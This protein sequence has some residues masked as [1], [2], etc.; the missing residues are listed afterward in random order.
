[1]SGN[2]VRVVPSSAMTGPVLEERAPEPCTVVIL[3]ATGDLARRKLVPALYRLL[4]DG[5]LPEGFAIVGVSRSGR[6]TQVFRASLAEAARGFL[7]ADYDERAWNDLAARVGYVAGGFDEPATYLRLRDTLHEQQRSRGDEGHHLFYLATPPEATPTILANLN[8]A[9]LLRKADPDEP[10]PWPRVVLEKPFGHDLESARGLNEQIAELLRERQVFRIDHY[11]GKETVQNIL[12]FRFGNA[13]FEPIWNRKYIDHVQITA[14]E[15]L[16]L[17][18][19]G[20]FYDQAGVVRDVVQNHLLQVLAL[21][22]MEPPVSFEADDLRDER[23]QVLRSLRPLDPYTLADDVVLAQVDGYHAEPQVAPGS[24]TPTFAALR[25]MVDNWRWQ[26]VPFYLRAGKGLAA[27]ATEVAI[28][29]QGVPF[30]LFGEDNVCQRLEPNV[31][32]L[33]IQPDE[34]IR[35]RFMTKVPGDN[36]NVAPVEMD[37]SYSQAF[38]HRSREAYERLLLDAMRGDASLFLRRDAVEAAWAYVEPLLRAPG[39]PRFAMARYA[40]GSAGPSEADSLLRA[41]GRS[42]GR[43]A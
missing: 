20:A 18:G 25:L 39:D 4:R 32:I 12:V 38:G 35:L 1:M 2:P 11:L 19:R 16:G 14:A 15:T 43:M 21:C 29:F 23:V 24:R 36:I 40:P 41:D 22:A 6:G 42:W 30:C 13:I 8:S 28:H 9:G 17:E 27:R 31:L 3:G 37:F 33:R 7:G 34:G 5:A 26:G 10:R